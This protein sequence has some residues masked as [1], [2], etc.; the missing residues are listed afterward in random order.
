MLT[1][2]KTLDVKLPEFFYAG[3]IL[4]MRVFLRGSKDRNK[5]HRNEIRFKVISRRNYW[6]IN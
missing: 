3:E 1:I 2:L 6:G 5:P 4:K